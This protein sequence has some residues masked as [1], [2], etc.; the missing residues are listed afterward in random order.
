MAKKSKSSS[1][2]VTLK[3]PRPLYDKIGQV[4][5]GAGY[6]SVTDF[7][8]YVLRDLVASSGRPS[9]S[10]EDLDK[11]KDRLRNLGYLGNDEV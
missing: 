11:V 8:V 2:K 7:V 1:E 6:N 5:E 4:I 3:I 10:G 9:G